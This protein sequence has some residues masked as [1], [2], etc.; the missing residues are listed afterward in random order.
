M[1]A[2]LNAVAAERRARSGTR[3]PQEKTAPVRRR[4]LDRRTSELDGHSVVEV[5]IRVRPRSTRCA[6]APHDAEV[7]IFRSES[8]YHRLV[9]TLPEWVVFLADVKTGHY[10][11]AAVTLL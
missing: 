1:C 5:E 7:S 11:V 2:D 4:A 10:D 9:L 3:I 6:L 8:R